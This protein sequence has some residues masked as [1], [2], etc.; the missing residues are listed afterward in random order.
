MSLREEL[1]WTGG[2]VVWWAGWDWMGRAGGGRELT[3]EV[4]LGGWEGERRVG[5]E[6]LGGGEGRVGYGMGCRAG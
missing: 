3:V 2:V 1:D 6:S 4:G 5:A